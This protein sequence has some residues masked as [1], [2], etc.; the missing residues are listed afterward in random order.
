M[1]QPVDPRLAAVSPLSPYRR[2]F[3]VLCALLWL[4]GGSNSGFRS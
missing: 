2:F 3:C 4:F 1:R